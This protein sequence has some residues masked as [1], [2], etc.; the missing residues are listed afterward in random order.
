MDYIIKIDNREKDIIQIFEE[1]G[2]NILLENC[3]KGTKTNFKRYKFQTYNK[4]QRY[5]N[6]KT[7]WYKVVG[8]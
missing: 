5:K 7:N 1:K 6:P 8:F 4:L 3:E 2:Y